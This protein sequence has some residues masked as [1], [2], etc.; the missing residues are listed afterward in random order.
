MCVLF[1]TFLKFKAGASGKNADPGGREQWVKVD[2]KRDA[3][4]GVGVGGRLSKQVQVIVNFL[5]GKPLL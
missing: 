3:A 1:T 2:A 5:G 4:L